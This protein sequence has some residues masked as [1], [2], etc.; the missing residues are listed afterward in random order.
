MTSNGAVQRWG[1]MAAVKMKSEIQKR[2]VGREEVF[3]KEDEMKT[4]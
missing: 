1:T 4:K 3:E 2:S